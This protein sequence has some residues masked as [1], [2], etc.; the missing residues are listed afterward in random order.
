MRLLEAALSAIDFRERP[1]RNA[2]SAKQITATRNRQS[3]TANAT[4]A[5]KHEEDVAFFSSLR[6]SWLRR[7]RLRFHADDGI[8]VLH[9]CPTGTPLALFAAGDERRAT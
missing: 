9:A 2:L 8:V 5:R 7:P 1:G 4:K 3:G 6:A